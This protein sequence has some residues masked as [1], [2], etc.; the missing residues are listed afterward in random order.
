VECTPLANPEAVQAIYVC[1]ASSF[2]Y[3]SLLT[4]AIIFASLLV[5]MRGVSQAR[6]LG[7]QRATLDLIEKVESTPHYRQRQLLFSDRRI[8]NTLSDLNNPTN[9]EA[10][11][12][13]SQVHDFLNHYELVSI[14]ILQNILDEVIY[15]DW[16]RGPFVRDWNA[17]A[18]FIQRERWKW[19]SE[20]SKWTYYDQLFAHFQVIAMRWS[21]EA[22]DLTKR[23]SAPP[24]APIGKIDEAYPVADDK[25]KSFAATAEQKS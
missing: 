14:G 18:N 17:A 1:I 10:K 8:Q 19:D 9:D 5:A 6:S 2:S 13:R 3:L 22:V 23:Y 25:E 7:R 20:E 4:P 12:E 16:M 24:P 11:E 15:R 21:V